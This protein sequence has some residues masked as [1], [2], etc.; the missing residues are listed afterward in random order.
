M[1]LS[2]L[3]LLGFKSFA[4]KTNL[5]FTKGISGIVGPNGCGKSNI[6]DA[7]R[8]VLGEQKTSILRS[9]SMEN[10]IFNGT[11]T[12]KPLGMAEVTITI[13]NN[14]NILSS[15]YSE[16][17]VTR[18]LYRSGESEYL[19]NNT[20]CRLKDITNTF[21]D[22][23]LGS[24]S[25]SVIELKMV[26]DILSGHNDR[27]GLFE[28]AAGIKKYKIQ[29][30][31]ALRKIESVS[32]DLERINDIFAE[33]QKNVSSLQRHAQKTRRYNMLH[34]EYVLLDKQI[35]CYQ[36]NKYNS[37][38]VALNNEI[39]EIREQKNVMEKA[40]TGLFHEHNN[41]KNELTE[42]EHSLNKYVIEEAN[43]KERIAVLQKDIAVSNEKIERIKDANIRLNSDIDE[44]KW[45]LE[46]LT[47]Q[48]INELRNN[49]E[50]LSEEIL[51]AKNKQQELNALANVARDNTRRIRQ[52]VD[53][54]NQSVFAL[55]SQQTANKERISHN[56]SNKQTLNEK[57]EKLEISRQNEQTQLNENFVASGDAEAQ[58]KTLTNALEAEKKN[59]AQQTAQQDSL[60]QALN[61]VEQEIQQTKNVISNKNTEYKFLHSL[62]DTSETA[63][64]LLQSKE[65]SSEQERL[66]LSESIAVDASLN[67]ATSVIFN[68]YFDYFITANKE[69]A[70]KAIEL[71]QTKSKGKSGFICLDLVPQTSAP[72]PIEQDGV[73]GWF[74]E[75][76]RAEEKIRDAVRVLFDGLLIVDSREVGLQLLHN[77]HAVKSV[78]T[79]S[80]ELINKAGIISGG[81]VKDGEMVRFGKHEKM[82]LLKDE[83][84]RLENTLKE[85]CSKKNGIEEQNKTLDIEGITANI[86]RLEREKN[87]IENKLKQ[88]IFAKQQIENNISMLEVNK[89]NYENELLVI[90][91]EFTILL[92]SINQSEGKIVKAEAALNDKK[93]ELLKVEEE[94]QIKDADVREVEISVVKMQTE[95][96]A[97]QNDLERVEHQQ[98]NYEKILEQKQSELLANVEQDKTIRDNVVTLSEEMAQLS[99]SV[100]V[101]RNSIDIHNAN[102]QKRT[103]ELADKENE[104]DNG[105]RQNAALIENIHKKELRLSELNSKIL[106]IQEYWNNHYRAETIEGYIIAEDFDEQEEQRKLEDVKTK[107]GNLGNINFAAIDEY[108]KEK[109]RQDFLEKQIADLTESKVTLQNTIDEINKTA[110]QHFRDTFTQIRLNFQFLF[111]KLF[112]EEGEADVWYDEN[113]PLESEINIS[114]KPPHKRPSSIEQLSAGEKT[115]T[116]IALLF[117]IY[118]VKPSPFCILDEVDAPLDDANVGR[119]LRIVRQFSDNTQ[120]L[121]VTHNKTTMAAAD[122]LYGVTMREHGVSQI[123]SVKIDTYDEETN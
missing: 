57:L 44:T 51:K 65:W 107:L 47:T 121:I 32:G 68:N 122:T 58:N 22:T 77:S 108:E 91:D 39:A 19:L 45:R 84:A 83:I 120:F 16:V 79:K 86:R 71:L 31:E 27:R 59:L 42:N 63:T 110:K 11:N 35:F 56:I 93:Q 97:V 48:T 40:N 34:D 82:N 75:V 6:V 70:L 2:K 41:L 53:T 20:K 38:A 89:N 26:E 117:A 62:V 103:E 54:V 21:M 5:T 28:E 14:K 55:Q 15:E 9:D 3:D 67:V 106:N 1:Y 60:K 96:S 46:K 114:A 116:A 24:D 29:V 25:Y 23:G 8:W 94:Q 90:E 99:A 115:L 87:E 13:E 4:Q 36:F 100:D 33:I 81:S 88:I 50:R 69:N 37:V 73:V 12:R 10:V 98:Q 61:A 123:A 113:D 74:S 105:R 111:K 76:I 80:G 92:A 17:V 118:M 7:I 52:E 66:T 78:I 95:L 109:E 104:I 18:R 72:T 102:K 85:L 101:L 64:F 49:K 119:F 30:K 43:V 112:D